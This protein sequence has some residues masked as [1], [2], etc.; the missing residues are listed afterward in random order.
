MLRNVLSMIVILAGAAGCASKPV[1]E[2][3]SPLHE[4]AVI[5]KHVVN[6]GIKGYFSSE[7]TQT[8]YLRGDRGRDELTF[9]GTGTFSGIFVGT[10]S[11]TSITRL[12]RKLVWKLDADK[13]LYTE[14]PLTGCTHRAKAA[15]P[16]SG[17]PRQQPEPAREPGC[18]MRI[19]KSQFTVTPTGKKQN[20]NGFDTDEYQLA[21]VVT[22]R[23][24][25]ARTK[26]SRLD[27]DIWTTPETQAVQEV[28]RMEAN[29][30]RVHVDAMRAQ[31]G[32]DG[33]THPVLPPEV[34]GMMMNYL[35][36]SL[37]A[38]E[39]SALFAAGKQMQKLKGYPILTKITWDLTGNACA[40]KEEAGNGDGKE[41]SSSRHVPTSGSGL[42][43]GLTGMFAEHKANEAAADAA[44]EPLLAFTIEV[45]KF[46]LEPQRDSLFEVPAGY[47]KA[48]QE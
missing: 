47:R 9:K 38:G 1:V 2:D 4:T 16:S 18:V 32:R 46:R 14:C 21:W 5:E 37:R 13:E 17:Q 8:E 39:H 27:M 36:N 23:D 41:R 44:R 42:A 7:S 33:A 40:P 12:D 19:A 45:K 31:I 10:H 3:K 25:Q 24:N 26:T 28:R 43:S 15:P 29:F 34:T 6:N 11:S 30:A 48:A 35:A 22:L 20:I